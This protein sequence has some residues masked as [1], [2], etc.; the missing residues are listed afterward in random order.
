LVTVRSALIRFAAYEAWGRVSAR[1]IAPWRRRTAH[2]LNE[3]Q[4]ALKDLQDVHGEDPEAL[5][6]ATMDLYSDRGIYPLG[7][8][9]PLPGIL[10]PQVPA[11]SSARRQ[12][13]YDWLA[14]TVV[15]REK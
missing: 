9:W 14:G 15:V 6:R 8:L 2:R 1:V 7:W 10:L 5:Q 4:S 12:T 11:L 3:L 13:A